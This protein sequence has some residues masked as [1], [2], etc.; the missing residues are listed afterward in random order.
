M[1][2]KI[3]RKTIDREISEFKSAKLEK[4]TK[5]FPKQGTKV[6]SKMSLSEDK[7]WFIHTTTITDIKS[8][9]YLDKV[10]EARAV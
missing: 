4:E 2:E 7:K 8:V 9:H 6:E 10:L 3:N 5:M 1:E